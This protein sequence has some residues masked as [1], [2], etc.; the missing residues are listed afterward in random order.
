MDLQASKAPVGD[1]PSLSYVCK[2][3]LNYYLG[4]LAI[5]TELSFDELLDGNHDGVYFGE[6]SSSAV[7][8][9]GI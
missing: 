1:Y 6:G 5:E 7:P 8:Y 3:T 9:G 2:N 4:K